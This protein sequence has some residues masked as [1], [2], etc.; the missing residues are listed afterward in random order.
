M[1]LNTQWFTTELRLHNPKNMMEMEIWKLITIIV[2][3][4]GFW[5][6]VEILIKVRTDKK[7]KSAETS[8]LYAQANSNIVNNW[9]QWSQKLE[10]R[11]KES[12]DH[13]AAMEEIIE[14]QRK[15]I[16]CLEQKVELMEKKNWF[17]LRIS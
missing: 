3:A 1:W 2:G 17:C 6:L 10:K 4:G 11:V 13:T 16:K 15:Q 9:V 14:K 5:K 7:L 12:E 8:N